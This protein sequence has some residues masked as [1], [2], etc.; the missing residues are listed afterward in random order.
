MDNTGRNMTKIRQLWWW[1]L[2][3]LYFV[4]M[5]IYIYICIQ[6]YTYMCIYIYTYYI[7]IC[8]CVCLCV[9]LYVHVCVYIYIYICMSVYIC[10]IYIYTHVQYILNWPTS[11]MSDWLLLS[12]NQQVMG[13]H[14]HPVMVTWRWLTTPSAPDVWPSPVKSIQK[15]SKRRSLRIESVPCILFI[16]GNWER[17]LN[18]KFLILPGPTTSST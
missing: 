1:N 10:I 2:M 15:D 3:W 11:Q 18:P 7:Y 12:P 4:C 14:G 17:L 9:C 5:Y 6:I 8:V 16:A 13:C